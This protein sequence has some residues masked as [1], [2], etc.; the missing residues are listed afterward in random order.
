[1]KYCKHRISPYD[2]PVCTAERERNAE[3]VRGIGQD[4]KTLGDTILNGGA[5]MS[6]HYEEERRILDTE[7]L[8]HRK[9]GNPYCSSPKL[10]PM[11]YVYLEEL[12]NLNN[13]YNDL[14]KEVA[15]E[16]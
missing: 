2:C 4:L 7:Y 11:D 13:K 16:N 12:R 6:N 10:Q 15:N 14:L 1:M 8:K 5:K 9:P 3:I